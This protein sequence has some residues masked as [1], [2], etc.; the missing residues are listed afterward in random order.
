MTFDNVSGPAAEPPAASGAALPSRG[1]VTRLSVMMFLQY[2]IWGAWLPL[3]FGFLKNHR[4]LTGGQIGNLF[5]ISALG[6]LAAPFVAGQIA[7]RWFNTERFLGISH[8]VGAALVWQLG[9]VETY[10]ELLLFGLLYSLVYA[11]TL[12]LTNSLA[13]HHLPDR[14]RDFG[15][16]RVWGTIGWIVVGIGMGQWIAH[17]YAAA[18]WMAARGDAFGLS[19]LLGVALGLF[20]FTLPRT[21]PRPG[22][23]AFAPMGAIREIRASRALVVLLLVALPMACV[24]QFYFVHTDT[25]LSTLLS[26][27]AGGNEAG[28]SAVM[29]ANLNKVFGASGGSL[30]TIGQI[31]EIAV[32][33]CMPFVARRVGRKG[34]LLIGLLA[35]VGRFAVFA[36]AARPEAVVPAL[37]LHG[38]C[39]GCFWFVAF[40]I[41]D[42]N[43]SPD[44]RAS[45]Q[46]VFNLVFVGLGVMLGNWFAGKVSDLAEGK[47]ADFPDMLRA[48]FEGRDV[49]SV[50][51]HATDYKVLYGVPMWLAAAC[52]VL[53]LVFYPWGRRPSAATA[54]A[55]PTPAPGA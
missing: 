11:P 22:R 12:P 20:C 6:A 16:V 37:A 15:K 7:D 39:F 29:Q 21:P 40:L 43:T 4:S 14:D 42:E 45:A 54:P 36:Y 38:L 25:Y 31:A 55:A 5:A 26:P 10:N 17:Q 9:R 2:A 24:H 28:F 48:I 35:Y 46:G 27:K 47:Y 32:L 33:A 13:F 52:L 50:A 49:T 30:M 23:A 51:T 19:A 18:D 41:I 1:V 53:L 44:V 3:F 34:L 8:L